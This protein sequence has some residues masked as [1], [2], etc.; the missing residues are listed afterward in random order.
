MTRMETNEN[1]RF[2]QKG[3]HFF[4]KCNPLKTSL[5]KVGPVESSRKLTQTDIFERWSHRVLLM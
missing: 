1:W 2:S 3:P 5:V 4:T